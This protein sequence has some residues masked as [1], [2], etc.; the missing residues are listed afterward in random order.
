MHKILFYG[1]VSADVNNHEE[2]KME[3]NEY[4]EELQKLINAGRR[5][6]IIAYFGLLP[7][8][9]S[10]GLYFVIPHEWIVALIVFGLSLLWYGICLNRPAVAALDAYGEK[11]PELD[12]TETA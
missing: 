6:E 11:H 10:F 7:I 2:I 5:S 8:V 4:T 12:E 1:R 9:V 3:S